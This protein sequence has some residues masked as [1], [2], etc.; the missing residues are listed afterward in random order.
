MAEQFRGKPGQEFGLGEPRTP[1][2][3]PSRHSQIPL[4]VQSEVKIQGNTHTGVRWG[5][6]CPAALGFVAYLT[7]F[8]SVKGM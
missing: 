1:F 7:Q 3:P 6:G 2:R 4:C 8:A 5:D